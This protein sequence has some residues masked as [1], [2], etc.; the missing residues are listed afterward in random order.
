M[1]Y[2]ELLLKMIFGVKVMVHFVGAGP[3]D[4]ELITKKGA[5]LLSEADVVIYAGSL[6]NPELLKMCKNDAKIYNSASMTLDE[7]LDIMYEA[8]ENELT[9]IRL[10]TGDP[11][12]Y[13]AIEEQM[14]ALEEKSI[15]YD[16]T[17]G[18]SSFLGA[19]ASLKQEYTLPGISQTVIVTRL[20][21]RTPVPESES[22]KKLAAH[23]STM[24]IF[25]STHKI[26]E[27]VAEL[28]TGGYKKDTPVAVVEK[29]TWEDEKI[30]RGTLE[31]ISGKVKE[32][33]IEKTAMIVVSP[34]L[35]AKYEK[36]RLYAPDFSHGFR[37]AKK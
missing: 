27:V 29:A 21:G 10:H 9:T 34:C 14:D 20:G 7:V 25:L 37:E 28:T 8:E 2:V 4:P 1:F 18:V 31:N 17:P 5:R 12:I 3:G 16:V 13:G 30:V 32:A 15:A 24:C 36:S 35:D 22:L 26:D 33:G 19:A 23:K 6:V 11:A